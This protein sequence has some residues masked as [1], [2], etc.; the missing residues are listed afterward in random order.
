MLLRALETSSWIFG[1][2]LSW[3]SASQTS[4]SF[5]VLCWTV[6]GPTSVGHLTLLTPG[7]VVPTC[8]YRNKQNDCMQY[9]VGLMGKTVLFVN[10]GSGILL[11]PF[12]P[13]I[14]LKKKK[15]ENTEE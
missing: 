6:V 4:S 2:A 7:T 9:T 8:C 5:I 10:K 1:Q 3:I 11:Y 14:L 12:G 15:W 13:H